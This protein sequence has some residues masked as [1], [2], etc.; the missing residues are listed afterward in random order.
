MTIKVK[1]GG[2]E[3]EVATLDEAAGLVQRLQGQSVVPHAPSNE[4][5]PLSNVSSATPATEATTDPVP[6]SPEAKWHSFIASTNDNQRRVLRYLREND[7]ATLQEVSAAL[8][9]GRNNTIAGW[10]TGILKHVEKAG[11]KASLVYRRE[12]KGNGPKR[13]V[14]YHVG[15]LLRVNEVPE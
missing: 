15:S 6:L 9:E 5:R 10:L 7:G 14:R 3:V 2:I 12:Q 8:A 1:I 4:A 11:L 13:V